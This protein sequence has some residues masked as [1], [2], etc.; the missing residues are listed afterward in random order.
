MQLFQLI[1]HSNEK[2]YVNAGECWVFAY[3]KA[4]G[5][6]MTS[7]SF[8]F[9]QVHEK[10]LRDRTENSIKAVHSQMHPRVYFAPQL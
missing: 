3:E 5:K 7:F 10:M 6:Q 8:P 9:L 4:K 2:V 1:S